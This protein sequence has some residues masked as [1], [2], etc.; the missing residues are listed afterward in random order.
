MTEMRRLDQYLK[1]RGERWY[2]VRRIPQHFRC[3]DTR[4]VIKTALRTSSREVARARRDALA[5]ADDLYWASL[6]SVGEGG[7]NFDAASRYKA[8]KA[9]AFA[10]GFIYTPVVELA[11]TKDINDIITRINA[12]ESSFGTP[13]ECPEAEALLGA[14]DETYVTI[15]QAFDLYCEKITAG[16]LKGKS[17]AQ[18]KNWVKVKNC[19]VQNFI[20][21]CGDKP[22]SDVDRSDAKRFYEW[23]GK[24]V[25]PYDRSRPL[26][27]N[28]ANKDLTN[29]RILFTAF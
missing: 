5:E 15:S 20:K 9:R 6:S 25:D 17:P 16:D 24:R 29:L 28:R 11:A 22:M 18:R 14:V 19:A 27:A 1:Q 7:K 23:W 12:L 13:N 10:H 26:S 4:T 2:Y 8:A 3:V 21:L